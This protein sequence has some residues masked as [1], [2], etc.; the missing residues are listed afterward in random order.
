LGW[1]QRRRVTEADFARAIAGP[2]Q[3]TAQL[4]AQHPSATAGNNK[5]PEMAGVENHSEFPMDP[6]VCEPLLI[7]GIEAPGLEPGTLGL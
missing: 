6:D 7:G 5:K 3:S 1:Q 4:T 2:S